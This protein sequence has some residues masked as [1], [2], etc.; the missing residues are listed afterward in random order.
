MIQNTKSDNSDSILE[1]K[2]ERVGLIIQGPLFSYGRTAKTAHIYFEQVSHND[3]INFDCTQNIVRYALDCK[4]PTVY[5]SWVSDDTSNL[6][7]LTAHFDHFHI[8][9]IEDE[10]PMIKARGEVIT[11]NNK[12]RQIYSSYHG[13]IY[14]MKMG[15]TAALKVRSDQWINVDLLCKDTI[16]IIKSD[17]AKLIVPYL[18]PGAPTTL[19][20]FFFGGKIINLEKIFKYYL[21]HQ[22]I[23]DHVHFD[24]FFKF[25]RPFMRP[26]IFDYKLHTT[27]LFTDYVGAVWSNIYCPPSAEIFRDLEWRGEK[28]NFSNNNDKNLYITDVFDINN[29]PSTF[30]D[31]FKSIVKVTA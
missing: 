4:I 26:P 29:I 21:T 31:S 9:K 17:R 20:D 16:K 5:V 13:L 1:N 11:G 18:N 12:Y 7:S 15:C 22:E 10:T 8:L 3:C 30:S 2:Q 19:P 27:N 24:Y 23:F 28:F 6:E 25:C 14:L